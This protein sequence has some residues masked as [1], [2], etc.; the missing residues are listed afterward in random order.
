MFFF[1]S[2]NRIKET[3]LMFSDYLFMPGKAALTDFAPTVNNRIDLTCQI[4]LSINDGEYSLA[5]FK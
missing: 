1:S 4:W 5:F 2:E 3:G